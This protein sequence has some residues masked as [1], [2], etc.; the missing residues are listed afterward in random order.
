VLVAAI[1]AVTLAALI[2]WNSIQDFWRHRC[3]V[4]LASLLWHLREVKAALWPP[5]QSRKCCILRD[6]TS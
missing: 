3:P 2:S 5:R 1:R 4:L 6:G